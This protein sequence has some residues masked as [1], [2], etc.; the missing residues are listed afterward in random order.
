MH[1]TAGYYED[2]SLGEVFINTAR[3]GEA[4]EV[5]LKDCAAITSI[6]IQHGV[7]LENLYSACKREPDGS[8]G[9]FIGAVLRSLVEGGGL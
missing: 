9:S 1:I 6:A 4:L 7:T 2:D 3:T 5:L 8:P